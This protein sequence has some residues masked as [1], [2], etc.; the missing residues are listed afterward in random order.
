M[1]KLIYISSVAFL[2]ITVSTGLSPAQSITNAIAQINFA[3]DKIVYDQKTDVI[4]ASG[5]VV[6]NQNGNTL[7]A[8]TVI[9]D[10][11]TGEV[12][13]LGG[14]T[15]KETSGNIL[16]MQD[17]T[18]DGDLKEGFIN[19]ARMIFT[20]GSK[21]IAR[22]G[23]REGQLTVLQNAIYTP[24]EFC[25]EEGKQSPTWQIR[26]D[27]VTHDSDEK[28]IKY[29]NVRLEV[30]GIPI[31]YSPFFSHPDPTVRA[32]TGILP[33]SKLGRSSE[34]GAFIQVPY[35]F[36]LAQD[37][38][39]TFEPIFTSREG[40]VWAGL[41]RQNTGNGSFTT[42]GSIANVNERDNDFNKTGD[43][44]LRGHIFSEGAFDLNTLE[45]FGDD[46][47]WDYAFNWVSD[48]TY[49]RRYYEDKS[50]VLESHVKI[51]RFWDQNYLTFGSYL[52][53]GLD[54]E[55]NIGLTGQALPSFD[56]NM[57]QDTGILNSKFTFD[58]SGVQIV[59][60]QG[61]RSRRLSAKA[62]WELPFQTSMGDFYTL[63][64]SVRSDF[65]QNSSSDTPDLPQYAG[66]DGTHS[67]VLPKLAL[68]WRM[69]FIKSTSTTSQVLEPMFSIIAAP[70]KPNLPENVINFSNEDSR[71]FEF[72][73]NNLFSHNRFN[74]YDRWEG[75]TRLN[76]GLRYNLYT[77]KLNMTATL[78]Q[79]V[80]LNNTETFPVGSGYE[81]KASDFVG[82]FDVTY[83]DFIDYIHRF[84]LD[85]KSLTLRRNEL[86]L[87]AGPKWMK[88]SVRYLDLDLEDDASLI[89]TEL[90]NRREIGTGLNINFD[91]KWSMK[92]TWIKDIL[93]NKT[94]S[95]DAGI[96]YRDDCLEFGLTYER[97]FTSDRDIAPSNTVHFRII[98][99]N[100]G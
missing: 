46:W 17:A 22:S 44:E 82:R 75:G 50:D 73:E 38:D 61:M 31:L 53:Q 47:Q 29:K 93:N 58:A 48:D 95:Y 27:T 36:N 28:T 78:G 11:K 94:I 32:R 57:N 45:K 81:G 21:L 23:E 39:F 87:S 34:L 13:A 68:D 51:E 100:L 80:R 99:K 60:S 79:S 65:Y 85:K 20:D 86:I 59:R 69:P 56:L 37:K 97:R 40:V 88:A 35:Y 49:L 72:D 54:E 89:G 2:L 26:A 70:T 24:C 71:N 19:R 90:E 84:R 18:L 3:A 12:K 4:T 8:Q 1:K 96:I 5:N 55:D 91:E 77:D 15:I 42:G 43:H 41:Y 83:G 16:H 25:L 64:A 52:F 7:N 74:G 14:I 30:A 6:L 92:G 63:S 66:T 33:P 76:Y 9:Y 67:R 98:L 62:G 10:V